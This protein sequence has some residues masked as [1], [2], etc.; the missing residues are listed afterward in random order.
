MSLARQHFQREVMA[1][2]EAQDIHGVGGV[3]LVV[4]VV[5]VRFGCAGRTPARQLGTDRRFNL[6]LAVSGR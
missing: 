2:N 5:A 4:G 6:G 1:A 3:N